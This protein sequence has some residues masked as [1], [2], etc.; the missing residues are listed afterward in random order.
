VLIRSVTGQ[1]LES[2]E[3]KRRPEITRDKSRESIK[4]SVLFFAVEANKLQSTPKGEKR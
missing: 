4:A 1:E 2:C 3:N